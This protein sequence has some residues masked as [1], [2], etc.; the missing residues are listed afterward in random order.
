MSEHD[1]LSASEQIIGKIL[2]KDNPEQVVAIQYLR[3]ESAFV[4]SGM[5]THLGVKEILIPVHLVALDFQL[6]GAILSAILEKISHS[7]EM[8]L[9]FHY[10]SRFQVMGKEYSLTEYGE[11]MKIEAV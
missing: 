8:D 10:V 5:K 11:F 7:H 9:S 4:T 1:D 6:V 2:N 3:Q